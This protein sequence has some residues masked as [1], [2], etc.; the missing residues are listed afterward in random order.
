MVRRFVTL[1][2]A[3]SAPA[4]AAAQQSPYVDISGRPIKALSA[5]DI[6][7]LE[8][9]AGMGFALAAELNGYPGPKHVLELADS[10][11]LTETQA[12]SVR[13]VFDR[14]ERQAVAL[15]RELIGLEWRLD[16]LFAGGEATAKRVREVVAAAGV[17]RA[18]L[19]ATH[20]VAHLETRALL[21]DHQRHRY[22]QLRGYGAGH[23]HEHGE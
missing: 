9:G 21:D 23:R 13:A 2:L 18:N 11:A 15:G 6:A 14:M 8:A 5:E 7:R 10:L 12:D 16:S 22:D 20:L 4:A 3:A 1:L 19:R 17:T